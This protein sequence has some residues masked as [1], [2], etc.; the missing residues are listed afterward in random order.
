MEALLSL[1][2]DNIASRETSKV[3]KGLRC[4][5]GLLQQVC[6]PSKTR[7]STPSH[8]R[9]PSALSL[10]DDAPPK[11]LREL[12]EDPAFMEFFKLQEGFEWN[13]MSHILL[14]R[15]VAILNR[16]QSRFG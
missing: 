4:I 9:N 16:L 6:C 12:P 8:R 5:E 7:P 3:R 14:T 10:N 2:F 1:S 13:G 15:T 11:K